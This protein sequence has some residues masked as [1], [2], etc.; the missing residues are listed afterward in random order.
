MTTAALAATARRAS[1]AAASECVRCPVVREHTATREPP[2]CRVH[3]AGAV[4]RATS[5]VPPTTPART[6]VSVRQT[7]LAP[8]SLLEAGPASP[9]PRFLE[10]MPALSSSL[11]MGQTAGRSAPRRC[12]PGARCRAAV[13][14]EQP[15][16]GRG[17]PGQPTS[18]A[19]VSPWPTWLAL[20]WSAEGIR[21]GSL[22]SVNCRC[23]HGICDLTG[24]GL[25]ECCVVRGGHVYS[26]S[27]A[28]VEGL[29]RMGNQIEPTPNRADWG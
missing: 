8:A 19:R 15:A 5:A 24:E 14:E 17:H 20:L 12:R 25:D 27:S 4:A 23:L 9:A 13:V 7:A 3:V 10:V 1:S 2:K 26:L 6:T 11:R 16:R 28:V 29:A 21:K 22:G 18:R